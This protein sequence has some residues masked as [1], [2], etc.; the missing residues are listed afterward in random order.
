[1]LHAIGFVVFY[2]S[3]EIGMYCLE[4]RN[5]PVQIVDRYT[6]KKKSLEDEIQKS[7]LV[8]DRY[9]MYPRSPLC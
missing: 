9:E 6:H 1:M 3:C 4:L 5:E 7:F 2:P 8:C